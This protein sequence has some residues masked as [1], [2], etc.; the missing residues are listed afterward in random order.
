MGSVMKTF[1][2]FYYLENTIWKSKL[3]VDS[4]KKF[5]NITYADTIILHFDFLYSLLKV[6][7]KESPNKT[8]FIDMIN[9]CLRLYDIIKLLYPHNRC[10]I[11]IY[12]KQNKFGKLNIDYKTLK[13]II[14]I[15]PNIAI[16]TQT[17]KNELEY[18]NDN[19]Y[20]HIFYGICFNKNLFIN[21]EMQQW[22]VINGKLLVK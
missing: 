18:F 1:Q 19:N 21:C 11:I 5:N 15:I 16:V 17:D 2:D 8:I 10:Y 20:K 6:Q 3:S 22:N 13:T 7:S 9:V 14:D 12:T 4:I